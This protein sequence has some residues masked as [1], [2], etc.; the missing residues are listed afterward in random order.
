MKNIICILLFTNSLFAG[1]PLDHV[2]IG[3]NPDGTW[4]TADDY[5]LCYDKTQLYRKSDP[6]NPGVATWANRFYPLQ[7]P[8][9]WG[10][11][12]SDQPGF[13]Q[14]WDLNNT[15]HKLNGQRNTD[16]RL[17]AECTRISANFWAED[18]SYNK[19]FQQA[20]D[21]FNISNYDENHVHFFFVTQE[22]D[23][24]HWISFIVYENV[25]FPAPYDPNNSLYV[26]AAEY[27]IVFGKEPEKGDIFVDGKIDG[28]DL[29]ILGRQWLQN[30][31]YDDLLK[32]DYFERADINKDG[33]VNFVDYACLASNWENQSK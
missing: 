29:A 16:Y 21:K 3:C 26:A 14:M 17:I 27:T 10:C 19:I 31:L 28:C 23:K 18:A 12:Y 2:A 11:Y 7:G 30:A 6:A 15:E 5:E 33:A 13:G 22:P 20:G 24:T 9:Y 25:D 8:D 1:C 4:A 32:T